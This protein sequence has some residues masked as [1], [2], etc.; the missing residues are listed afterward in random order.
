MLKVF[1][2][3]ILF[4]LLGKMNKNDILNRRKTRKKAFLYYYKFSMTNQWTNSAKK[5]YIYIY[6]YTHTSIFYRAESPEIDS[7]AQEI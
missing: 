4:N 1:N 5:K 6:K 7:T 3:V 2:I